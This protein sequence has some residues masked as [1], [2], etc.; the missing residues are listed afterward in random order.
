LGAGVGAIT[1]VLHH[2]GR[3]SHAILVERESELAAL[4][5]QNMVEAGVAANVLCA[6]LEIERLPQDLHGAA[7][8]VV[9]NP[10]FFD[11]DAARPSRDDPARRARFGK[12]E[13]F[14]ASARL[15]LAGKRASA[16]F[17]YPSRSLEHL[18]D[19]ARDQGLTLKR[20]R[21]VHADE[22]K[23]ARLCLVELRR[24]RPGGLV[25][26]PPLYEWKS[27]GVPT[28]EL[29]ELVTVGRASGRS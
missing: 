18:V 4:A 5:R 25:I 8:L 16:C 12:L 13:P 28:P 17:A 19:A 7:D 3:T 23:P 24:A 20:L 21:F 14:L 27:T 26:E 29:A 6:D 22:S 10:P 15:A 11:P 9:C 2:L 1:L